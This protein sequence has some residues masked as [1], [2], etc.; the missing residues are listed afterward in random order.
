MFSKRYTS[1]SR[2]REISAKRDRNWSISSRVI[3]TGWLLMLVPYT[4]GA[5]QPDG[6][7]STPCS[8]PFIPLSPPWGQMT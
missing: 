4:F 6:Q 1:L 8:P 3:D 2:P 5:N 7:G